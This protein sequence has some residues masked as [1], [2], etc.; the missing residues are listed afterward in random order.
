LAEA[1]RARAACRRRHLQCQRL[2][3]RAARTGGQGQVPAGAEHRAQDE[4]Y[5]YEC[6]TGEGKGRPKLDLTPSPGRLGFDQSYWL[7]TGNPAWGRRYESPKDPPAGF[8]IAD[9]LMVEGYD[10]RDP[11][12]YAT[13]P[14]M[15][16]LSYRSRLIER[17]SSGKHHDVKVDPESLLRLIL[18]VD[19]MAPYRGSEEVRAIPD[20]EFQGVDWLSIRPRIKTAPT[21]TRPGPVD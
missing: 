9:M 4:K 16:K 8:G 12:G 15:T 2:P 1:R 21:I 5:C 20:P 18:W 10:Q 19:T 6:H 7:F 3:G 11:A 13:P 17:A 14:P